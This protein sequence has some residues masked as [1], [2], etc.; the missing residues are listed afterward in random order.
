MNKVTVLTAVFN[1]EKYLRE[2][3]N[4]VL[5]QTLKDFSLVCID[6]ASTDSTPL[7]LAEYA[8]ADSRVKVITHSVNTGQAVARN[9]GLSVS[10]S[11]YVV[12]LDADD[13]LSSDALESAVSILDSD[14]SVGAVLL[15]LEYFDGNSVWPY[16]MKSGK[17]SWTGAEAFELSLDWSIHG[18]YV[19]RRE[20]YRNYP[21]DT[22]CRLYSDDNTTRLHYLHSE[23]VGRCSGVYYYR[24]HPESMTN[25][26]TIL[27]YDLLE[28]NT[29]MSHRLREEGVGKRQRA[30]F[31]R[32]RWINLTGICIYW[33]GHEYSGSD[34]DANSSIRE[35]LFAVYCDVDR[36]LLP[37]SL[38]L[39]PGYMPCRNFDGYLSGVRMYDKARRFLHFLASAFRPAGGATAR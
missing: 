5:A 3:L 12:M 16:P 37:I 7:I 38:R 1:G 23:R 32:E 30:V 19:A 9:D 22:S 13:K 26:E 17:N 10:D 27:R 11:E 36:R 24:Q 33:F 6:D 18:L 35:R 39:K 21:F 29:S 20:L 34:A 4:S 25:S 2:A 15:E 14:R 28:A 8:T 31:E